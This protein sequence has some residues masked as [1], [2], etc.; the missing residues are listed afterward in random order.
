MDWEHIIAFDQQLLLRLNG[1]DSLFLDGVMTTAT[2]TLT[3]VPLGC[4]LFY[5]FIRNNTMREVLL[6]LGMLVLVVLLA[7]QFSSSFCKPFFHRFRPTHDPLLMYRVDVVDGYRG[8]L[9]GFISSHAANTFGLFVFLSL[10]IRHRAFTWSLLSWSLLNCYTR[11][12]LG[13]HYP[14]DILCGAL[15]GALVGFLI[16]LLHGYLH[17]RFLATRSMLSSQYTSGG[18]ALSDVALL[19]SALYLSY[20]YVVV[21]GV[22]KAA[23]L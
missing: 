16:Y 6:L 7:D 9:Y 11:L 21:A 23:A 4:V 22:C 19:L 17:R 20:A 2:A 10:L 3:W 1:S 12:Y 8:G 15:W 5:V 14:G 13:V 18:Y